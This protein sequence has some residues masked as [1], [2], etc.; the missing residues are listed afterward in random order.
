MYA[1][2]SRDQNFKQVEEMEDFKTILDQY[3]E[4]KTGY[5]KDKGFIKEV[6]GNFK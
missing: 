2:V 1:G 3:K 6:L 5:S 4:Y